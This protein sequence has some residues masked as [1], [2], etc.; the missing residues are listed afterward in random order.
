MV[1]R[2]RESR[3]PPPFTE[4]PLEQSG[5]HFFYVL[6]FMP[7]CMCPGKLYLNAWGL[8]V[9]GELWFWVW[10]LES[11]CNSL[12]HI[13]F[14][15]ELAKELRALVWIRKFVVWSLCFKM[16]P[17]GNIFFFTRVHCWVVA[18]LL[19]CTLMF[20][21]PKIKQSFSESPVKCTLPKDKKAAMVSL[22]IFVSSGN[23]PNRRIKETEMVSL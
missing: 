9:W 6:K 8:K 15:L 11:M 17:V 14:S 10:V 2:K 1:L 13:G 4:C 7:K 12:A 19:V 16:Q 18:L 22:S 23:V 20:I 21:L 5:G 3:S